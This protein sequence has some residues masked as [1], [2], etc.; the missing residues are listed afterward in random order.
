MNI[1]DL[2]Q[3]QHAILA[4]L[5]EQVAAYESSDLYVENENLKTRLA[6]LTAEHE[7]LVST[8]DQLK[9]N[10]IRLTQALY[11]NAERE[12]AIIV[13][14]SKERQWIYFNHAVK[15]ESNRLS[16]LEADIRSRTDQFIS[17]LR[18]HNVDMTYP[19]YEQIQ[20]FKDESLQAI[21]EA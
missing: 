7:A 12:R 9:D 18:R 3:R 6:R 4:D 16:A 17:D 20:T 11:A 10:N 2:L 21:Q 14:N 15:S 1:K 8:A 19:L 5:E 13:A